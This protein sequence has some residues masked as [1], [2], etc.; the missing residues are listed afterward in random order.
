MVVSEEQFLALVRA[1]GGRP[2]ELHDGR[3]V[4]KPIMSIGH[5][6]MQV[7]LALELGQQLKGSPDFEVRVGQALVRRSERH[8]FIPD[9]YVIHRHPA[10]I[11]LETREVFREPL[12][13]VTEI[14]SPSTG[15]YDIDKKIPQYQ[16]RGDIEIWRLHP[17]ERTLIAWRRQAD[18][19][20]TQTLFR[21]GIVEPVALPGMR[22]DL[23]RLFQLD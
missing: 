10:G 18:G 19:S 7:D 20:Y 21:G 22:I 8:F 15:R 9:V 11:P 1:N 2:L 3:V 12:P 13:L 6:R 23:D 14:W 16:Q 5:N 4:E 17:F